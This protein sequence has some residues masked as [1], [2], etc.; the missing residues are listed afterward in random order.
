M[1]HVS[2][3]VLDRAAAGRALGVVGALKIRAEGREILAGLDRHMPD[4]AQGFRLHEFAARLNDRNRTVDIGD[5]QD[6]LGPG[7]RL[8]QGIEP[9]VGG[10]QRFFD[11]DGKAGREALCGNGGMPRRWGADHCGAEAR[12]SERFGRRGETRNAISFANQFSTIDIRFAQGDTRAC[13]G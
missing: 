11:E 7:E 10:G 9:L 8:A 6:S 13:G 4:L 2:E 12:G 3:K 5:A 1:H